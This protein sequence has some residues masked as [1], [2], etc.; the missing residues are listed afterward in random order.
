MF[1]F[2][3][4]PPPPGSPSNSSAPHMPG[5]KTGRGDI[6]GRRAG[7]ASRLVSRENSVSL[8]RP[9]SLAPQLLQLSTGVIK[10][11]FE[12]GLM[13]ALCFQVIVY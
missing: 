11:V 13:V 3:K 5:C 10:E 1:V 7:N 2:L 12:F 4:K 8:L 9:S 6:C